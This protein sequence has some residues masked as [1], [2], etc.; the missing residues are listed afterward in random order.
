MGVEELINQEVPDFERPTRKNIGTTSSVAPRVA[1]LAGVD[2]P[3]A[4]W[5][6]RQLRAAGSP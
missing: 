1:P 5:A 3:A 2:P 4:R 6:L